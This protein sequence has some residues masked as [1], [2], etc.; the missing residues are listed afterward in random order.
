MYEG[1]LVVTTSCY[2]GGE[3]ET[4]WQRSDMFQIYS[5]SDQGPSVIYTQ[6]NRNDGLVTRESLL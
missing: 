1:Q 5:N 3:K 4:V 2:C 6:R